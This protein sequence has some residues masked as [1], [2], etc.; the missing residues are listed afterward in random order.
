MGRHAWGDST[1]DQNDH[2]D[3]MRQGG[4]VFR[5]RGQY[6]LH[7]GD[8]RA[9]V[10]HSNDQLCEYIIL[11]LLLLLGMCNNN[12]FAKKTQC[13]IILFSIIRLRTQEL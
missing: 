2:A 5:A 7:R 10:E 12:N 13:G 6:V 1:C 4:R 11:L 9:G 3:D 8:S